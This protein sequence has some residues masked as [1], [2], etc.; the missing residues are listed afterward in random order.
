M[1]KIFNISVVVVFMLSIFV[2][3]NQ[4]KINQTIAQ[5]SSCPNF[6][7]KNPQAGSTSQVTYGNGFTVAASTGSTTIQPFVQ[8][9]QFLLDGNTVGS[10]TGASNNGTEWSYPIPASQLQ[11]GQHAL[12]ARA[13]YSD[14]TNCITPNPQY[15]NLNVTSTTTTSYDFKILVDPGAWDLPTYSDKQFTAK[16]GLF[17]NG[18]LQQDVTA[19]TRFDW[20]PSLGYNK[21]DSNSNDANNLFNSGPTTGS[22]QIQVV[23]TYAGP[24]QNYTASFNIKINVFSPSTTTTTTSN[25]TSTTTTAEA[26]SNTQSEPTFTNPDGSPLP[27]ITNPVEFLKQNNTALHDCIAKAVGEDELQK[28][29]E[30]KQRPSFGIITKAQDCLKEQNYVVPAYIA[31]VDPIKIKELPVNKKL[32]VKKIETA[33]GDSKGIVLTGH[34]LPNKTVLIYVFSEPLVLS[35]K[36]DK[37][38]NWSY[39]LENPL[40]PGNHEAY[41]AVEGDNAQPVRSGGFAFSV[42]AAPKTADN[43]LGLSFS[44]QQKIDPKYFYMLYA[45]VTGLIVLIAGSGVY[46]FIRHKKHNEPS[47]NMGSTPYV[48]G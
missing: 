26:T 25:N 24:N 34:G 48:S 20:M 46:L 8:Y 32:V 37:D 39:T 40:E 11:L 1:K 38:G 10:A 29:E 47:T 7:L 35:A 17:A 2:M 12:Q 41:V 14:S 4:L 36:T 27:P 13:Y 21:P 45:S 23:G 15:M 3:Q 31:P 5:S 44:V 18:T 28:L 6:T 42:A 19:M 33:F 22:G 9:V 30:S 16:A 43:P